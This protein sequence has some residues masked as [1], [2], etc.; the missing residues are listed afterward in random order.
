MEDEL[1]LNQKLSSIE[2]FLRLSSGPMLAENDEDENISRNRRANIRQV[3]KYFVNSIQN[4]K[5]LQIFFDH[6][7]N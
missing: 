3:D 7:N 6:L 5:N 1:T 2:N 4:A